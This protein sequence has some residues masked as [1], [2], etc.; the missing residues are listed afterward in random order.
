M[1]L[2]EKE[3]KVLVSIVKLAIVNN[4]LVKATELVDDNV[5]WFGREGISDLCNFTARQASGIMSSLSRKGLI[6]H[7]DPSKKDGWIVTSSG[8]EV[9]DEILSSDA[10][11]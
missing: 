9:A 5:A 4:N 2:S 7:F 3:H 1:K 8:L 10:M 6:N 11:A